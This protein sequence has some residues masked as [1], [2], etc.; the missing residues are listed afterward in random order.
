MWTGFVSPLAVRPSPIVVGLNYNASLVPIARISL[1]GIGP[2][3]D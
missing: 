3:D 2:A 1:I